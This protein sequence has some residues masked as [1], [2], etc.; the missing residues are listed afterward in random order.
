MVFKRISSE[1]LEP[2]LRWASLAVNRDCNIDDLNKAFGV[3]RKI[4]D[5]SKVFER[6][7]HFVLTQKSEE[8]DSSKIL[9]LIEKVD[10]LRRNNRFTKA[11]K[12]YDVFNRSIFP[13]TDNFIPWINLSKLLLNLKPSSTKIK[14]KEIAKDLTNQRIK[15]IKQIINSKDE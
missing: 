4:H 12:I 2:E 8:I 15:I 11:V 5:L 14:G 1:I 6:L 3:P 10:G 7:I 13:Q 9:N